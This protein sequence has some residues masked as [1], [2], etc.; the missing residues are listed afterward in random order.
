M[1]IAYCWASGLVE[2]GDTLPSGAIRLASITTQSDA[3]MVAVLCR[4]TYG[5]PTQLLVPGIPEATTS[6]ERLH[7]LG[8]FRD[9]LRARGV[10]L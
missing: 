1:T 4:R 5:Q 2:F 9:N 6:S 7:A 3:D 10:P 8:V